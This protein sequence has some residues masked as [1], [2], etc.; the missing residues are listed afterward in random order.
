MGYKHEK[1]VM[2]INENDDI[3]SF[4]T[5]DIHA[6][7]DS[8]EFVRLLI[9][10][11]DRNLTRIFKKEKDIRIATAV[12]QLFRDVGGIE[13]FK[14]KAL[15][16][17]IREQT[18]CDTTNIKKVINKMKTYTYKQLQEYYQTGTIKGLDSNYFSYE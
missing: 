5:P 8:Q 10:F 13:N 17:M 15:Y 9:Q 11:W 4:E 7:D 6:N 12:V 2:S 14:K 3:N 1:N 18:D 16:L